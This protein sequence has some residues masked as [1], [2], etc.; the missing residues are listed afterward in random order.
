MEVDSAEMQLGKTVVPDTDKKVGIVN[1]EYGESDLHGT[2]AT[3]ANT[4]SSK[5]AGD[6]T[7]YDAHAHATHA[8]R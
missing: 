4:T 6:R 5:D 7:Q 3:L 1:T 8:Q 2:R